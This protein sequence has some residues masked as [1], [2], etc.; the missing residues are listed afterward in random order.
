[1]KSHR[2]RRAPR[3]AERASDA[4]GTS[5]ALVPRSAP[6]RVA[7]L[8][9][10]KRRHR[11]IVRCRRGDLLALRA[12]AASTAAAAA[13]S[14]TAAAATT[15]SAT[16][17]TPTTAAPT[18]AAPTTAATPAAAATP[19]GND[20]AVSAGDVLEFAFRE[21]A[22]SGLLGQH[23]VR[24]ARCV[25][26]DLDRR[27][28]GHV[29][30][31]FFQHRRGVRQKPLLQS[32]IVPAVGDEQIPFQFP[33]T[34][35]SHHWTSFDCTGRGHPESH[36]A[37]PR[38]FNIRRNGPKLL[39]GTQRRDAAETRGRTKTNNPG[40]VPRRPHTNS[41][42]PKATLAPSRENR[43]LEADVLQLNRKAT[44]ANIPLPKRGRRRTS[45]DAN[46]INPVAPRCQNTA[47]RNPAST[48]HFACEQS[49]SHPLREQRSVKK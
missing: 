34:V 49:N 41:S 16:A 19:A 3:H 39:R 31:A 48:G 2:R 45:T 14:A 21:F 40:A 22:L 23:E 13:A 1:M 4:P 29:D 25:F 11:E 24:G 26:D 15:A 6:T 28:G 35:S 17:A 27:A 43:R 44:R 46:R 47:R 12:T 9:K 8:R 5:D 38:T 18:T 37:T 32:G 30:S 20:D 7:A 36:H 33:T 42:Y 10:A